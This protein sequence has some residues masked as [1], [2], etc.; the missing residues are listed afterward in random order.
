MLSSISHTVYLKFCIDWPINCKHFHV[1][2]PITNNTFNVYHLLG[3]I[4]IE[5]QLFASY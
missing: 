3:Q 5:C 4:F 2:W 1:C